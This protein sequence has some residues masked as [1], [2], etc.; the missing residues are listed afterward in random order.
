MYTWTVAYKYL[1]LYILA[2]LQFYLEAFFAG[3]DWVYA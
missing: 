1:L 2:K 3:I